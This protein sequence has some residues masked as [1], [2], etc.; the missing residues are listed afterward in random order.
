MNNLTGTGQNQKKRISGRNEIKMEL[1]LLKFRFVS[2]SSSTE[3]KEMVHRLYYLL[4][5]LTKIIQI[6]PYFMNLIIALSAFI[7]AKVR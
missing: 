3:K 7:T 1:T 6:Y 5:Q 2:K 4:D